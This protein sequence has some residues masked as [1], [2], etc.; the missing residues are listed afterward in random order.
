[1]LSSVL[2]AAGYRVGLYV[3]PHL[4]A[5]QERFQID[6]APVSE[7]VFA[8]A[9]ERVREAAEAMDD[10]PSQFELSTAVGMLCYQEAGCELVVLE[11]GVL[12]TPPTPSTR[13]KRRSLP[14]SAWSTPNIWG[15]PWR[16]LPP[17]R[18]GLSNR[19]VTASATTARQRPWG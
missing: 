11:V 15:T 6:G 8:A 12:W 19:G 5:F 13:R 1:M 4:Q 7:A 16:R 10:H 9:A 2:R 18:R 3:S 14:T 17:P